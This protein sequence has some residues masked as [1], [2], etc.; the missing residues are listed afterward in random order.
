MHIYSNRKT[1]GDGFGSLISFNGL[2]ETYGRIILEPES[3]IR[4]FQ[5]ME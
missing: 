1:D 3:V 2:T 5:S 4:Y